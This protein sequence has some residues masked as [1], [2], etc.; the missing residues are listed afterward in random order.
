MGIIRNHAG[1]FSYT[2][3]YTLKIY[4]IQMYKKIIFRKKIYKRID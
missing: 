2:S 4:L 3:L 1:K